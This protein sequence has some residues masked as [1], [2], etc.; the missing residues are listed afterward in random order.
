[1]ENKKFI[2]YLSQEITNLNTN[3]F[4]HNMV[5]WESL[6]YNLSKLIQNLDM[7]RMR[8]GKNLDS[9]LTYLRYS[10]KAVQEGRLTAAREWLQ[11]GNGAL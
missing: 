11:K 6:K 5:H 1:M 9:A 4:H 8:E 3:T 2:D 10:L 7:V